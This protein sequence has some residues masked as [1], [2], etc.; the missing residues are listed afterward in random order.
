MMKNLL[1]SETTSGFLKAVNTTRIK[2]GRI[3]SSI[4]GEPFS[5]YV[6][7]RSTFPGHADNETIL[8]LAPQS[9]KKVFFFHAMKTGGVTFRRILSSI[10]G[11][12]FQVCYDPTAEA[13]EASLPNTQAIEFHSFHFKGQLAH[14]HCGLTSNDRWDI[15]EGHDCFTMLREPVD[16]VVSLYY[17]LVRRRLF[18]EPVYVARGLHFPETFEEFVDD[19]FHFNI[20]TAFLADK[21]QLDNSTV[22]TGVDLARAKATLTRL[23]MHVGLTER[24]GDSMNIFENVTGRL[25][26]GGVI[27]NENRNPDRMPVEAVSPKLRDKIREQSAI[28]IELYEFGREMFLEDFAQVK[29]PRTY[30]F[31][32][33]PRADQAVAQAP[34]SR[35]TAPTVMPVAGPTSTSQSE[36]ARKVVFFHV[37][38]TGGMTFRGILSSIYADKFHVVEKPG[39][40]SVVNSLKSFDCLEFHTSPS[41]GA[42]SPMHADLAKQR[43]WDLLA[44]ADVFTMFRDPVDQVVSQFYELQSKRALLEPTYK[45]NGMKFP[46]T[47]D[48]YLDN[49]MHLNNQLAFLVGKSLLQR[50]SEVTP[51]DLNDA[52]AM[53]IRLNMHPG[54]TER[55]AESVHIFETITGRRIANGQIHNQ[56]QNADR[57]PLDAISARMRDRIRDLSGFDIA[58]YTF[59]RDIFMKDVAQCGRTRQYTFLDGVT[60]ALAVADR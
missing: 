27:H 47:M 18:I 52:K 33:I 35:L 59:A 13:I 40:E 25:I 55:F 32:D 46:E 17:Y 38:Q 37:M 39:I 43:R 60:P 6:Q 26:P 36:V 53:L 45:A 28:D 22:A 15:L 23:K 11:N 51:A 16:Q 58:L 54:L 31:Q 12:G 29:Q 50:G 21:H 57:L 5:E 48:K 41:Q 9:E 34:A 24:F 4:Y 42:F 7:P 1:K 30:S 20:Q 56:K 3:R 44:G 10:Y 8:A 49:P 2:L 14:M 19:I